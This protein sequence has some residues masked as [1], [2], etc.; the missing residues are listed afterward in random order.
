MDD[1]QVGQWFSPKEGRSGSMHSI[2]SK[3][4]SVAFVKCK[5]RSN[6]LSTV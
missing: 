2:K 6:V 5:G 3:H 1:C 4:G